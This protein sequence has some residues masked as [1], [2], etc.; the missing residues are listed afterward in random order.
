MLSFIFT[1]TDGNRHI[2]SHPLSLTVRMDESVPADDLCAVFAYRRLPELTTLRMNDDRGTVFVGVV[3]EQ[4]HIL[5]D[6]GRLLRICARSLAAHLLDNEAAPRCYDHPS[7]SLIYERH[8][9]PY[10]IL[11]E[12]EDDATFFGEQSVG[13]GM[14]QWTVLKNFCTACYSTTPR[15]TAN[16][17]LRMKGAD[18]LS[19]V[20]FSDSGDGLA[21]TELREVKKRCEEISRVNMKVHEDEGYRYS[22]D[23]TDALQR[24]VCRER[25]LNAALIS[26]PMTC[27]D[28]MIQNGAAASYG[29]RL[30]CSGCALDKMGCRATVRNRLLGEIKDLYVSSVSYRLGADG[31]TTTLQLKRRKDVCGYQDM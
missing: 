10:G 26:T 14:S 27:A 28:A 30:K 7:A 9:R 2:L 13:K 20:C 21:Y 8:V 3:D 19:E 23:N 29:I 5:S 15:V 1:D 11:R 31:D 17:Y 12:E 4:E 6:K 16:G 25:Y 24:G 22:V 18:N